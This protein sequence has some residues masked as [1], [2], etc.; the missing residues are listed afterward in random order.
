MSEIAGRARGKTEKKECNGDLCFCMFL[1]YGG[2]ISMDCITNICRCRA[3]V[4]GGPGMGGSGGD[5]VS[6]SSSNGLS[7]SSSA[8]R[9]RSSSSNPVT[10]VTG[11]REVVRG[12]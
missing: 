1:K 6:G 10:D 3:E 11:M 2:D 8:M 7:T 4:G 9:T 12:W 5:S